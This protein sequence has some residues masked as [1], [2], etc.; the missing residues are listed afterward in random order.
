LRWHKTSAVWPT[1]W[2]VTRV[3]WHRRFCW[4]HKQN[5]VSYTHC[6]KRT[7]LCLKNKLLSKFNGLVWCLLNEVHYNMVGVCIEKCVFMKI[8][9]D[10]VCT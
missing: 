6:F 2:W 1:W 9:L 3:C 4:Q 5:S 8:C 10:S 7:R